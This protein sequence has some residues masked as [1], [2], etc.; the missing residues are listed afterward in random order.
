LIT[1]ISYCFSILKIHI[2][3]RN[4]PLFD[5]SSEKNGRIPKAT[6]L[7]RSKRLD[8]ILAEGA[9]NASLLSLI[10]A[11]RDDLREKPFDEASRRLP[12]SGTMFHVAGLSDIKDKGGH[13]FYMDENGSI[14]L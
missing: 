14:D 12:E 2:F 10:K 11:H 9:D 7:G 8:Q 6:V 1:P 4:N 5:E 3:F 13:R